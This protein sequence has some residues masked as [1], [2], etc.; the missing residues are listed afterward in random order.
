M[1]KL[2]SVIT[3]VV[4]VSGCASTTLIKT[5]PDS[6]KVHVDGQLIGYSPVSY[7]DTA[8]SGTTK[9]VLL[10]KEGYK[11]KTGLIRKEEAQVG[12]I[13]GGL[14]F[15]FPFIWTL[16]YPDSYTFELEPASVERVTPAE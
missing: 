10:K 2:I 12:P 8:V 1:R 16:G 13:I 14:F 3:I 7:S 5:V 6:A 11:D 4:F 15:L 9:T